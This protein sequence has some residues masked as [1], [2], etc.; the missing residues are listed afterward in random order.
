MLITGTL[1]TGARGTRD[2]ASIT[3]LIPLVMRWLIFKVSEKQY[4]GMYRS[5][6]LYSDT[7]SVEFIC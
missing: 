7:F 3:D 6:L 2:S 1:S 4:D 5:D